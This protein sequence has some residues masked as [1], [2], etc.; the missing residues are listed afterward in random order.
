[1]NANIIRYK[2]ICTYKRIVW[3]YKLEILKFKI[4]HYYKH[5]SAYDESIRNTVNYIKKHPLCPIPNPLI[6]K[7][8]WQDVAVFKDSTT[9]LYYVIH[10]NK[11]LFFKRSYVTPVSVQR[12][13]TSLLI[14]QD[15]E[16]PHCYT[17][18][19]FHVNNDDILYDV[20]SAEGIFS[21]SNIEKAKHVIL[22]EKDEEWIE[23]LKATFAP[24]KEKV[25]IIQKYV[26]DKNDINNISVDCF[27]KKSLL[28]PDFMKVD[29]EGAEESVLQGMKDTLEYKSLKIAL[30]TY[31]YAKDYKK[32]FDF[33]TRLHS[34][35]TTSEGFMIPFNDMKPPYLRKGLIRIVTS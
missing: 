35:I 2:L 15:Q 5:Q 33:F 9:S 16:S 8:R 24:W 18:N 22:F 30:C 7:Y 28:Q 11:K 10:E 14:E 27:I 21:L 26:C 4:I 20:G 12:T 3:K 23:A 29:V 25:T 1:M 19:Q 6:D 17:D 13:Y 32:F 31:H 34:Q